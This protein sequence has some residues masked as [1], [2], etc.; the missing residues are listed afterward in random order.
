MLAGYLDVAYVGAAPVISALDSGL[1]AKIV[2]GV[3]TQGSNLVVR[4]EI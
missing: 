3:Q 1:D 2:A 4:P